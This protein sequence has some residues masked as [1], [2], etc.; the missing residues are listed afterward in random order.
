MSPAPPAVSLRQASADDLP[1]L[2]SLREQSMG[3]H[4]LA[5]GLD[6]G[7]E[8]TRDRVLLHFDSARL[9]EADGQPIGL[10]KLVKEAQ[11]W[12]ILQVQLLPAWQGRKIGSQ[13]LSSVL[14]EAESAG[15]VVELSVLKVNPAQRLYERLGFVRVSESEHG[16][17]LRL[18][19]RP[20]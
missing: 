11:K 15:V 4:M 14:G 6:Q 3:L 20:A 17:L 18:A 9:I 1:F 2:L 16:Y 5:A 7:P 8:A 12:T 10:L 19:R 13:L